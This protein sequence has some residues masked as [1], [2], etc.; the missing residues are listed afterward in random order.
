MAGRTSGTNASQERIVPVNCRE[1][2][3][4]CAE[5]EGRLAEVEAAISLATGLVRR[6]R[7]WWPI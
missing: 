3:M 4:T 7:K 5:M 1:G 2:D 6:Q